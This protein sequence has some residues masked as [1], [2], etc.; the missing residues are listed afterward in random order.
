KNAAA[1]TQSLKEIHDKAS[2]VLVRCG[3]RPVKNVAVAGITPQ[4][5]IPRPGER[6][7]FAVLIRNSGTEPVEKL[8]VSLTV[9]GNDKAMEAQA[10]PYI[11]PG[12]TKAVALTAKL[13]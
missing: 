12:E 3:T 2:I 9:D 6:V 10:L 11:G 4:S 13:D 5:E 8:T 7:G 1:L